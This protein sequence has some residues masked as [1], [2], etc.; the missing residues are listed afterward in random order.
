MTLLAA[1]Q[2]GFRDSYD[3]GR[4]SLNAYLVDGDS[5]RPRAPDRQ[6]EAH[7]GT[8]SGPQVVHLG[9]GDLQSGSLALEVHPQSP[10]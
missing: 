9:E 2:F 10:I 3:F 7:P 1:G 8:G 4:Q 6:I 5:R